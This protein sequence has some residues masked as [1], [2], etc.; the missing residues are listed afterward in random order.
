[1]WIGSVC[2]VGAAV[3]N[4]DDELVLCPCCIGGAPR[5]LAADIEAE[6][7]TFV[8]MCEVCENSGKVPRRL[9]RVLWAHQE[10]TG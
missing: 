3:A 2:V 8:T 7:A 10:A 6:V 9:A 5:V 1:M 4:P